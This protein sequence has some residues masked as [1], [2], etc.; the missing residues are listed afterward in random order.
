MSPAGVPYYYNSTTG[1]TTWER[2]KDYIEPAPAP[3]PAGLADLTG[4]DYTPP[5]PQ[6][7]ADALSRACLCFLATSSGDEPHLSLM[8]FTYMRSLTEPGSEVLVMSTRRDTKKFKLF[9]ANKQVA[10][11]VH[12]FDSR[13]QRNSPEEEEEAAA[14][15]GQRGSNGGGGARVSITLNGVAREETGEVGERYRAAHL[16]A[17]QKYSQFI[18]GD[19]IAVIIVDILSARVCDVNDSVRHFARVSTASGGANSSSSAGAA[20]VW[21]ES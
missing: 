2:P 9:M 10:L 11:L 15:A 20:P 4:V 12:D 17:N 16:V 5:L 13:R 14:A 7:V 3:A 18:E 8:R 19:H 21:E 6:P 1:V